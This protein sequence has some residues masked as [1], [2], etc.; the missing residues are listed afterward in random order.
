MS[1]VKNPVVSTIAGS[2][3]GTYIANGTIYAT[4]TVHIKICSIIFYPVTYIIHH[5]CYLNRL[6]GGNRRF[7]EIENI[8][9]KKLDF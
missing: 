7:I 3:L 9:K 8:T 1:I 2:L 5:Y 4:Y 6:M